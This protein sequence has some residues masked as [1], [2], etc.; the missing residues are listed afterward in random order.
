[1]Q[2]GSKLELDLYMQGGTRV[3]QFSEVP[4]S[5][6]SAV[7]LEAISVSGN[8]LHPFFTNI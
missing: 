3:I 5:L 6:L 2:E 4:A 1:M 8:T 7:R